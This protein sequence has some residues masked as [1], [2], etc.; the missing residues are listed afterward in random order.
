MTEELIIKVQE[1][2][3]LNNAPNNLKYSKNYS[4]IPIYRLQ[5]LS[6]QDMPVT[7]LN[8]HFKYIHE[9]TLPNQVV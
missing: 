5:D 8:V 9:A 4:K 7:L 2:S 1:N 3:N 6:K